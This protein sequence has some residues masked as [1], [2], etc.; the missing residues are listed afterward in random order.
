MG[1]PAVHRPMSV[2]FAAIGFPRLDDHHFSDIHVV[3][4]ALSGAGFVPRRRAT[5]PRFM[6]LGAALYNAVLLGRESA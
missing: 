1:C 2:A 4:R 3:T 5:L 6:P